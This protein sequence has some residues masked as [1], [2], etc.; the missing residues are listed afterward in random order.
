MPLRSMG[1]ANL[2]KVT[3]LHVHAWSLQARMSD[4]ATTRVYSIGYIYQHQ[5]NRWCSHRAYRG[6]FA[7]PAD[8]LRGEAGLGPGGNGCAF[9]PRPGKVHYVG[10]VR[11]KHS[12]DMSHG[13][14]AAPAPPICM[15]GCILS[16]VT[17]ISQA[18]PF[19]SFNCGSEFSWRLLF[20]GKLIRTIDP[21]RRRD[22]V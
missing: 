18:S 19:S 8:A 15:L 17:G 16:S 14:L 2:V 13:L 12:T 11:H 20:K 5:R 6:S 21:K 22:T 4:V 10:A 7:R 3:P 9:R 1:L